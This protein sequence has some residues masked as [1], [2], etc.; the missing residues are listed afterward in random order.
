MPRQF[1]SLIARTRGTYAVRGVL[2][3]RQPGLARPRGAA[4]H[5]RLS[6]QHRRHLRYHYVPR[7]AWTLIPQDVNRA[8]AKIGRR[9]EVQK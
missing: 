4:G 7:V 1:Q 8:P 6:R 5:G 2:Y 3:G 9:L